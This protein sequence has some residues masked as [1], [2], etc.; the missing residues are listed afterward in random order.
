MLFRIIELLNLY[1]EI[2]VPFTPYSRIR[3][4]LN[5]SICANACVGITLPA[6]TLAMTIALRMDENF[7]TYLE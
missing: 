1:V 7:M 3:T 5:T 6:T 4:L 2:L